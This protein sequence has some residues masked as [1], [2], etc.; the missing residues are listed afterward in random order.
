MNDRELDA[1]LLAAAEA[2]GA[3]EA[4]PRVEA[5]LL[6]AYRENHAAPAAPRGPGLR[7]ASDWLWTGLAAAAAVVAIA[8]TLQH[9]PTPA[10]TEVAELEE[11]AEFL[12]LAWGGV[13]IDD[14]EAVQVVAVE[15]P[16]TALAGLGYGGALLADDGAAVRAELLVGNDGL[17]R[18]IRFVR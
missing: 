15:V 16:R 10:A 7:A 12:P 6:V 9:G 14:V 5:K 11:E 2:D 18:G 17:A 13:G 4:P 1:L 3:L 8:V